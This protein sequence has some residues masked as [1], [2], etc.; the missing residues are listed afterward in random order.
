MATVE[1]VSIVRLLNFCLCKNDEK[2]VPIHLV[3]GLKRG[4]EARCINLT[5]D[6][7]CTCDR[8][9]QRHDAIKIQDLAKRRILNPR[10]G[11]IAPDR[12]PATVV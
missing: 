10:V 3:M 11:H 7:I 6:F 8:P 5:Y 9:C 2:W 12:S 4:T 1:S